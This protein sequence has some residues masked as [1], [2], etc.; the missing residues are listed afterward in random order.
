MVKD[1]EYIRREIL[2][3]RLS[4]YELLNLY[5]E[6]LILRRNEMNSLPSYRKDRIY[7]SLNKN[8]NCYAYAFR[9]DMPDYFEKSFNRSEAEGFS[10]FPGCFSHNYDITT[11]G[12]LLEALY[13]DLDILK[14]NYNN[15]S[16]KH[17]YQ[18]A[19]YQEMF[20]DRGEMPDFHFWR[21]NSSGIWSC[22]NGQGGNIIK[23]D[24]PNCIM[25]YRLVKKLTI[26]R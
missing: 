11:K 26:G 22:K 14:I 4:Y 21:Q 24:E 10:Y 23:K 18:V 9:F 5:I 2:N 17:T 8:S 25:G 12:K 16:M 19:L 3:N 7:Y 1:I 15:C 20:Y 6:Y 13:S